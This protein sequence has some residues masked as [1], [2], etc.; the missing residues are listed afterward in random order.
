V[1]EPQLCPLCA[2][3]NRCAMEVER[4]T[5]IKQ[6]PCWCTQTNFSADLLARIPQSARGKACVCA[7]CAKTGETAGAAQ[8]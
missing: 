4:A 7:A 8:G 5:G 3:P 2:Q 1:I 6:P